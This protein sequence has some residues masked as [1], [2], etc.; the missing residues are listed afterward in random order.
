[1]VKIIEA[2]ASRSG[3]VPQ[4]RSARALIR[5]KVAAFGGYQYEKTPE[6][7][8]GTNSFALERPTGLPLFEIIG[9]GQPIRAKIQITQPPQVMANY[10]KPVAG[11]GGLVQGTLYFQPL[12]PDYEPVGTL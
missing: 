6:L 2:L 1:M 5:Q 3:V 10:A 7:T 8:N 11:L 9:P 4:I 12:V